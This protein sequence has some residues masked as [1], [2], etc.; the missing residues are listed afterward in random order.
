MMAQEAALKEVANSKLRRLP[1]RKKSF[2]CTDVQIGDAAIFFEATNR[3][4]KPRWRG[5][6][7]ILDIDETGATVKFQSQTSKV[8]RFCVRKKVEEKDVEEAA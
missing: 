4:I 7:R 1:A 3:K 8:A 5:P 6:E 2:K